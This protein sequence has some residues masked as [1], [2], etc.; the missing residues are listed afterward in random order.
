MIKEEIDLLLASERNI[1]YHEC[2]ANFI[3]N[4]FEG[5]DREAIIG[6]ID[7]QL[8]STK[9]IEFLA[10]KSITISPASLN[11][12]RRRFRGTGC[13]CSVTE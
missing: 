4:Q 7:S 2:P 5:E 3:I 10:S 12:H 13:A 1:G 6:L 8:I 9:V 11:K